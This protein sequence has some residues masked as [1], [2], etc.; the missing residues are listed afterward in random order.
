ML[1]SVK[2]FQAAWLSRDWVKGVGPLLLIQDNK[3]PCS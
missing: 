3:E 2:G 1:A